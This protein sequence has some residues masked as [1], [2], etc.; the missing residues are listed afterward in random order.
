M[1]GMKQ[2][3][4]G[5]EHR[6]TRSAQLAYTGLLHFYGGKGRDRE[7]TGLSVPPSRLAIAD[8]VI[9]KS[10]GSGCAFSLTSTETLSRGGKR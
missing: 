2:T 4:A 7:D 5:A 9:E 3:R 1:A 10:S 6:M 8:E